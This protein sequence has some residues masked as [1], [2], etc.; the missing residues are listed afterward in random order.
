MAPEDVTFREQV[1]ETTLIPSAAD[2]ARP[3]VEHRWVPRR[4]IPEA[5]AWFETA[6]ASYRE[7]KIYD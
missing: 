7:G 3:R 6:W 2:D 4:P 5:G 1:L